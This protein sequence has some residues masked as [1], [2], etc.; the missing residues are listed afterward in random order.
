MT[1]DNT[2]PD[3]IPTRAEQALAGRRLMRTAVKGALATLDHE[4]GHPYA[5]L[6]LV[7]TEPDGTPVFLLSSLARHGKNLKKDPRASLLL[8]GTGD[9]AEPLT[10]DRLTLSGEVLPSNSPTAR[11]RF[12]A[13]HASAND[14]VDFGDFAIYTLRMSNG[15]FI[16]G[17]GRIFTLE[18]HALLT[19]TEGAQS[20]VDA[21]PDIIAHMNADHADAVA[22]Y[23][24]ELAG[25]PPG[26]PASAWRMCGIDPEGADL[27]QCTNA[28]RI[29]F[30]NRIS[31][32]A[33][34]RQTLVELVQQARA[35]QRSR[36]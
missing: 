25:R 3:H 21:E 4:T 31:S 16:G 13:R 34:A 12:L 32:P 30:P 20:L 5:S 15:H 24:T 26:D 1:V 2:P 22:L 8:D 7:A 17:F 9:R 35:R 27:L 11:R 14:Y 19:A 18:A 29:E 36:G 28:A 10:G 23:A 33:E 6:V